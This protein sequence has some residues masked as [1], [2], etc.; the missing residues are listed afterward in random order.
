MMKITDWVTDKDPDVEGHYFVTF[1][2]LGFR[3]RE[4]C[5]F[6]GKRWNKG[7]YDAVVAWME[8]PEVYRGEEPSRDRD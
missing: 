4:V 2:L 6:D 8:L 1:S 3:C 7:S 5:Y